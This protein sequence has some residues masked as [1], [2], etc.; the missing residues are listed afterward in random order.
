[1]ITPFAMLYKNEKGNNNPTWR[2]FQRT[3]CR[4]EILY[5]PKKTTTLQKPRFTM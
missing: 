2:T 3:A 5:T 4:K 1:M